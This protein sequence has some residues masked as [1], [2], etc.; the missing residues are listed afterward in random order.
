[1][2]RTTTDHTQT[3]RALAMLSGNVA[4]AW[5][6][7]LLNEC[8]QKMLANLQQ[9][10]RNCAQIIIEAQRRTNPNSGKSTDMPKKHTKTPR[11]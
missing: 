5:H 11:V 2:K 3:A 10:M 4:A 8:E 6:D 9:S 1:M 7:L